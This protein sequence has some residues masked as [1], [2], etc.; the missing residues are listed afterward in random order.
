MSSDLSIKNDLPSESREQ[1]LFVNWFR[2]TH[3]DHLIFAI[4]NG[5]GRNI[6]TAGR[7]KMEG[8]LAGVPDLFIPSLK[9]WIEM[10][11]KKGGVVSKEQK[12]VMN[13]LETVGYICYVAHGCDE[14]KLIIETVI[15]SK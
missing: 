7:L 2:K 5:G 9:L 4:P 3:P 13:Y 11:R 12:S 15:G 14:A 8:V 6:V 1:I 10:K